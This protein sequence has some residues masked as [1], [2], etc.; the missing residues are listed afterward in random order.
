MISLRNGENVMRT[1][2][3]KYCSR[4]QAKKDYKGEELEMGMTFDFKDPKHYLDL[5]HV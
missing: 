2:F 4:D 3:T 1:N 5:M